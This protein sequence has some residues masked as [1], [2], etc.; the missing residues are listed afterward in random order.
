MKR[1]K[2]DLQMELEIDLALAYAGD[3]KKEIQKILKK[4][5]HFRSKSA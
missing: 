2:F 1:T 5:T 4:L 3:D